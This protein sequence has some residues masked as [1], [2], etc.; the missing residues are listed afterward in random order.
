MILIAVG[1]N[2]DGPWGSPRE[3][4]LRALKS[5]NT[6]PL[7]L[8]AASTLLETKPYGVT[9]QPNFVNAVV[10][11]ETTL[12]AQSLLIRLH[13]IEKCAGRKRGRKWGPRTLDLD[14]IDYRGMIIGRSGRTERAL[15]LPHPGIAK[16]SFV[17]Q[18]ISEIAPRWRHP[19]SRQTAL[20]TLSKL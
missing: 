15:V 2:I 9:N 16:R 6:W 18:P 8:D 20:E 14:V 12:T 7:K 13:R 11:V 1:S 4:V 19:I 17:L 3:T 10:S 5:L